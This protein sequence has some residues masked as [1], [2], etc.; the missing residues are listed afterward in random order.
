MISGDR[1][2]GNLLWGC[3]IHWY[4]C[5][6]SFNIMGV[7]PECPCGKNHIKILSCYKTKGFLR[8]GRES[9]MF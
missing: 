1:I 3:H 6:L 5:T 4:N 9:H 7:A 2:F 8:H